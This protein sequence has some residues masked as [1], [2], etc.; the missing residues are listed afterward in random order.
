LVAGVGRGLGLYGASKMAPA[1]LT[2]RARLYRAFGAAAEAALLGHDSDAA[3]EEEAASSRDGG[4]A[5][6]AGRAPPG[7]RG[8]SHHHVVLMQRL[9]S[10]VVPNLAEVEDALRDLLP[11]GTTFATA[12][13]THA[14]RV[15]SER[16]Y[17]APP[18]L[19]SFRE[20]ALQ[21]RPRERER[22]RE[23]EI[24]GNKGRGLR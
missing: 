12:A 24:T 18:C 23:R 13:V 2:A 6:T 9:H 11:A 14:L 15:E 7:R 20:R 8:R 4:E 5:L 19:Q 22:E 16:S 21:R 3:R 10:R 17:G 1:E